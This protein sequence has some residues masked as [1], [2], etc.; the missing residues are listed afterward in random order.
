MVFMENSFQRGGWGEVKKDK[1]K[2]MSGGTRQSQTVRVPWGLQQGNVM[3]RLGC[4]LILGGELKPHGAE[5]R[6]TDCWWGYVGC[7]VEKCFRG[8]EYL[9]NGQ[10]TGPGGT[11][12][13]LRMVIIRVVTQVFCW[14]L[15]KWNKWEC[16]HEKKTPWNFK[17]VST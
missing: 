4:L 12:M 13:A 14:D 10:K 8:R 3:E 1:M 16:K 2:R 7:S 17:S 11:C 15:Q 9:S 6:W 5:A